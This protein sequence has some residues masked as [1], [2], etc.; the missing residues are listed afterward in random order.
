MTEKLPESTESSKFVSHR[1]RMSGDFDSREGLH[2]TKI[3]A[4]IKLRFR[5]SF[6]ERG[7]ELILVWDFKLAWKQVLFTWSFI[8]AAFQNDPISWWTCVG[9]SFRVLFTWYFITR[10][11]TSFLPKGPIWNPYP[12]WVSNAHPH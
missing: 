4:M 3:W 2:L 7:N 12:H 1:T 11:K 5:A 6:Y 8:S 9:I 10:N